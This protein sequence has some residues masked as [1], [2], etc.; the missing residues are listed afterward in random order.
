MNAPG[1]HAPEALRFL[2][3]VEGLADFAERDGDGLDR[4]GRK[5]GTCEVWLDRHL[6]L[7]SSTLSALSATLGVLEH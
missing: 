6:V 4:L 3:Y 7:L 1:K 2:G 5:R